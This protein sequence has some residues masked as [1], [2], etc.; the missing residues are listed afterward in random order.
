MRSI[1]SVWGAHVRTPEE[2]E[3]SEQGVCEPPRVCLFCHCPPETVGRDLLYA[4]QG[5]KDTT[6]DAEPVEDHLPNSL[7][8]G[9]SKLHSDKDMEEKIKLLDLSSTE[10]DQDRSG[11]IQRTTSS[12]LL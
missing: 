10:A 6:K 12:S 9:A 3:L 7:H 8:Q 5:L 4:Y 11:G 1:K 2:D